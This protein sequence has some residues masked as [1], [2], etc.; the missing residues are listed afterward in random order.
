[1]S[2]TQA[3]ETFIAKK[4]VVIKQDKNNVSLFEK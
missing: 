2:Q 3:T 1:M 4:L